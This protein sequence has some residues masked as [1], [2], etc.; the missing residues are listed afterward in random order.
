MPAK[1]KIPDPRDGALREFSYDLRKLGHG[2]RSIA[3]I[4]E[5]SEGA[6]SRA[7]LYA[8]MSGTRLPSVDT[9]ATLLRWWAGDPAA[10]EPSPG[11]F[12]GDLNG[13]MEIGW[14]WI[15]RLPVTHPGR[16][17][18]MEWR[19]RYYRLDSAIR[20]QRGAASK[21]SAVKIRVPE[22]QQQFIKA[23]RDLVEETGLYW[24][25]WL[26]FGERT[27]RFDSYL[28]GERI[29]QWETLYEIVLA[30]AKHTEKNKEDALRLFDRFKYLADEA[31]AARARDRRIARK[32]RI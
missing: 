18:G 9:I 5:V 32:G 14:E 26:L 20:R 1:P 28:A 17:A 13:L 7:A 8:A 22:E 25:R 23:L 12:G 10:E 27:R 4:A 11:S 19:R 30:C 16:K 31:R 6:V 3:F 2:K 15:E 29:P 21:A 24:E